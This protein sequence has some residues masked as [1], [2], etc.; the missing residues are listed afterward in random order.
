MEEVAVSI[1]IPVYN[2]ETFLEECLNSVL[3]QSLSKIE[4][5][6]I[7]DGSTDG[8][9]SI[10]QEFAA[11]DERVRILRQ[12]NQGSGA[13]RNLGLEA[14]RGEFVA[15]LDCDDFYPNSETLQRMYGCAKA[16]NCQ[17]VGGYH[18]E[19]KG[20]VQAP[21][22][23]DPV[24]QKAM[25]LKSP[26]ILCYRDIQCDW[27]YQA[28]LFRTELLRRNTLTF[29][30]YL[31]GQDP[32]FFVRAMVAAE[33]FCLMPEITYC[34]RTGEKNIRWTPRKI[35]DLLKSHIELLD[36]SADHQLDM[37]HARVVSRLDGRYR[38]LIQDNISTDNLQL[39]CL[40]CLADQRANLA[41]TDKNGVRQAKHTLV[42]SAVEKLAQ[43]WNWRIASARLK[44][45]ADLP[46]V[47]IAQMEALENAWQELGQT[48]PAPIRWLI[49]KT[50]AALYS[51]EKIH[52]TRQTLYAL[53]A[54]GKVA[55]Y[56]EQLSGESLEILQTVVPG[57]EFYEK[58]LRSRDDLNCRVVH[59]GTQPEQPDVTVVIPV[60]NV[61]A[62]LA[63]CLDSVVNQKD[64]AL[65]II[66]VDDGSTDDSP[67][68]LEDYARRYP[69]IT[70]LRQN[71]GGLAAARNAG[72]QA[73]RGRYIQYLD[74]DDAM[75][76]NCYGDL[77]AQ[78]DE[79]NLDALYFNAESFYESEELKTK[80]PYYLGAYSANF[81]RTV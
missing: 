59:Q 67:A 66:C 62:Y 4:V 13:A 11:M 75:Q 6:C 47:L 35:N 36:I 16:V 68:I 2:G 52:L 1:I 32:P 72:I 22:S 58:F 8:S 38:N 63:E 21:D 64:V 44:P 30:D 3:S 18:V 79:D 17:I 45:G 48:D 26:E 78:M 43:I 34:Y 31:R 19:V 15:F 57:F 10:L 51:P 49:G 41:A 77:V 12:S 29:P 73:A 33:K 20:D 50:L 40:V 24:Y 9:L 76:G 28:F 55:P 14:V 74:S 27:N 81:A 5:I 7:D 71:N 69:N 39:P 46:G 53:I 23:T 37:L 70:V 25:T 60:Y 61:Q 54:S 65:E 56:T 80:Y 42:D